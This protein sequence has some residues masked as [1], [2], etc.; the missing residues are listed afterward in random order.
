MDRPIY[1]IGMTCV[2]GHYIYDIIRAFRDAD[3]FS[4]RIVGIDANP[5]AFGRLLV[6][7]FE[8]VPFAERSEEEYIARIGEIC[9]THHLDALIF[10]SESETR[11][12]ARHRASLERHGAR[13][14]TLR[15]T[16]VAIMI[17]KLHCFEFLRDHGVDVGPFLAVSSIS[18]VPDALAALGYPNVPVV[19]KPRTSTGSRGILIVDAREQAFRDLLVER[20]CGIGSWDAIK[21][22]IEARGASVDNYLA[23]P[24]YGGQVYDVDCLGKEGEAVL[25]VPRLRQY[26]NPLSPVNEGCQVAMQ[27]A[28]LEFVTALC[29]AFGVHGAC[30]FDI[31]L[32]TTGQPRLLDA[33]CRM[34]G[35]VGAAYA[36]GANIPAQLVRVLLTLPLRQYTPRD[37][38]VIR[39]VHHLIAV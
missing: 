4:V 29:R 15:N 26:Q 32:D 34:S 21:A 38:A 23:M 35:S 10:G 27:P 13:I 20:L 16:E 30:D 31:A 39:P 19:L 7:R 25:I 9:E 3:D 5:D 36:A 17:D 8:I 18:E 33:S 1:T 2:G 12:A 14:T 24:Y 6:D 11:V 28:I 37:G 22:T